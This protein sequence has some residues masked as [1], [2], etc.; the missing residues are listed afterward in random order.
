M[1]SITQDMKY[2][3]SLI[4][5]A[6]KYGVSKASRKYNKARSYI[7]FWLKR[8]DGTPESLACRSRSLYRVMKRLGYFK[9]DKPKDK[10]K[11]KPM[12]QMQYL[13]TLRHIG[14]GKI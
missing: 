12:E 1:K 10:N 5:Y 7:Y 11:S 14:Q 3:Q 4:N 8:Y 2:R 6:M 9:S 13:P